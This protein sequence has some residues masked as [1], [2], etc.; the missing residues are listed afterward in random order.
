MTLFN[1]CVMMITKSTCG[2]PSLF[3]Q[4]FFAFSILVTEC[5]IANQELLVE[6]R[7]GLLGGGNFFS[8]HMK[9]GHIHAQPFSRF[10]IVSNCESCY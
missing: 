1:F 8:L 2:H 4:V 10:S 5:H 3:Y 9:D 7:N 6:K